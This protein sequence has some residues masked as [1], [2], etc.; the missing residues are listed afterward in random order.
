[1]HVFLR[2]IVIVLSLLAAGTAVAAN[3]TAPGPAKKRV[4]IVVSSLDKKAPNLVGG[5]WFPELTHP[6]EVFDHAGLD[7]DIASPKG[8]LAPFDGFDLTDQANL[9]FWTSPQHRNKLGNTLR[10]ATVDPANYAAI[11]LVG[12]HGPMWDFVDN[13]ELGALVRTI[14]D[15]HGI[16]SAVCHGPAGLVD[17]RLGNGARLI[18]GRRLTAFTAE[19]EAARHYDTIVPFELE[20][21]LK[22]AG[23]RFEQASIFES[24][25]VVDDRLITGQNPASAKGVGEAVVNALRGR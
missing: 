24:R 15:N 8:G 2:T 21:A 5:F 22:D 1:M 16:V 4:L 6:V 13:P 20:Q 9:G 7:Y 23:A 14:Y 25:V 19:E 18:D 3:A 11:L 12:G 10:L 17:V